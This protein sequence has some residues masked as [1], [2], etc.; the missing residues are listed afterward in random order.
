MSKIEKWWFV[1]VVNF[2][3]Q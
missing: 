3:C 1:F 2:Y